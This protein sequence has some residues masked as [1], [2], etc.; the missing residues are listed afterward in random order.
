MGGKDD[1]SG[2]LRE[3]HKI[4]LSCDKY[5]LPY[6]ADQYNTV[7]SGHIIL[8]WSD[9]GANYHVY[10]DTPGFSGAL[11]KD[12]VRRASLSSYFYFRKMEEPH[13][14]RLEELTYLFDYFDEASIGVCG[15]LDLLRGEEMGK[16]DKLKVFAKTLAA[17]SL[18]YALPLLISSIKKEFELSGADAETD[19]ILAY[20]ADWKRLIH[21]A[22]KG[23]FKKDASVWDRIERQLSPLAV[24]EEKARQSAACFKYST[25]GELLRQERPFTSNR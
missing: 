23:Y 17:S 12:I 20:I 11:A 7:H 6:C 10:D 22:I 8:L 16:Q 18:F 5:Y 2:P 4:F 3:G 14:T 1:F 24:L 21:L 15:E 25:V 13:K 9:T 19:A